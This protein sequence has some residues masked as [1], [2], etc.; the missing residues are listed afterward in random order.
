MVIM[1]SK[2]ADSTADALAGLWD[3][4]MLCASRPTMAL[5]KPATIFGVRAPSSADLVRIRL[6]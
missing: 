2:A 4:S 3:G 5:L 1:A 6:N